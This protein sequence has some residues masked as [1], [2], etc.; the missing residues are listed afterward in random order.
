M[1]PRQSLILEAPQWFPRFHLNSILN[2]K[3]A[4]AV[5]WWCT[6]AGNLRRNRLGHWLGQG[7]D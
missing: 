1:A 7:S 2:N 6:C 3:P 5:S 4:E